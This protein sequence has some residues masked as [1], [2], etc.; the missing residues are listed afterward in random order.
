MHKFALALSLCFVAS[1]FAFTPS[2]LPLRCQKNALSQ[3]KLLLTRSTRP[4][5]MKMSLLA[6]PAV[7]MLALND[8]IATSQ[9]LVIHTIIMSLEHNNFF[10]LNLKFSSCL[11]STV[12]RRNENFAGCGYF[13]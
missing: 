13:R 7:S 2:T 11:Q 1:T 4:S 9:I 5:S 10:H 8:H 3:S 6:T 12:S